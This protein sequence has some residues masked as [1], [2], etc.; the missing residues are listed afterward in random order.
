[1]IFFECVIKYVFELHSSLVVKLTIKKCTRK[2][3]K[4]VDIYVIRGRSKFMGIR[5]RE[6]GNYRLKITD[7]PAGPG[8]PNK[9][10]PRNNSSKI[11]DGPVVLGPQN[12]S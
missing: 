9:S 8:A 12:K 2:D 5:G 10:R 3:R 7:D 6:M 11:S 4:S 1:M